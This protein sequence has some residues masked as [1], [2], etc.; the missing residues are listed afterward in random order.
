MADRKIY[1]A[2]DIH[3]SEVCIRKFLNAAK[4]Y[5]C[6]TLIMGGDITGKMIVPIVD[7]GQGGFSATLYGRSLQVSGD[8][9]AKLAKTVADA[10]Y[11][12]YA[13]TPAEMDRVRGD[14]EPEAERFGNPAYQEGRDAGDLRSRLH[15]GAGGAGEVPADAEP[16]RSHPRVARR[17]QDRQDAGHQPGQRVLRR[18]AARRHHHAEPQ[19]GGTWLSARRRLTRLPWPSSDRPGSRRRIRAACSPS[20]P[21]RPSPLRAG[22]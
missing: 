21:A 1:F 10:G 4:F 15:R 8:G 18:G 12:A 5:G 7:R 11:Y 13:T 14:S 19:E 3:G 20:R 17:G 16:A 9:L 6:D 22:R 2:T